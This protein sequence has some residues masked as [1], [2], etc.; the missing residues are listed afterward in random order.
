M[1]RQ[2]ILQYITLI[3]VRLQCQPYGINYNQL[4]IKYSILD[5]RLIKAMCPIEKNLGGLILKLGV[6]L[7]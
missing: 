4:V 5:L 3:K 1:L 6:V 7:I 2:K